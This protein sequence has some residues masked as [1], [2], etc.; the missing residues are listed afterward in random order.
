[1]RRDRAA[2]AAGLKLG[3]ASIMLQAGGGE[4]FFTPQDVRDEAEAALRADGVAKQHR[5][6]RQFD[7]AAEWGLT[8]E[9]HR[10]RAKRIMM[11]LSNAEQQMLQAQIHGGPLGEPPRSPIEVVPV[12]RRRR[13]S[14]T[15]PARCV[16]QPG[17]DAHT[18]HGKP[19]N[20]GAAHNDPRCQHSEFQRTVKARPRPKKRRNLRL[21]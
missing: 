21:N 9:R 14:R 20:R 19:K 6:R 16:C 5:A 12:V 11:L 13:P 17:S 15:E 7:E 4:P 10:K 2:D 3:V 18:Q 8:A 1:V